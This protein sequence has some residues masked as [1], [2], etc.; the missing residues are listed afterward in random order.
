MTRNKNSTILSN[1]HLN[2]ANK[3]ASSSSQVGHKK[4]FT[5]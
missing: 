2:Q 1:D 5:K 3:T 4:A